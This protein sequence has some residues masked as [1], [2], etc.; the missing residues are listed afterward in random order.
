MPGKKIMALL[1]SQKVWQYHLEG[2]H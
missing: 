1:H 2:Y